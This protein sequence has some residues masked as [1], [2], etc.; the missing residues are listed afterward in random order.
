SLFRDM[1]GRPEVEVEVERGSFE[2]ILGELSKIEGI[3][4]VL[5]ALGDSFVVLDGSGER[6]EKGGVARSNVV[7]LMPLPSGGGLRVVSGVVREGEEV[8]LNAV[9]EELSKLGVGAIAV[10][11][12]VVKPENEGE[13]VEELVYEYSQ[14]L[15]EKSLEKIAR[16]VGE[17]W[18]LRGVAILHY[19]GR[20]KP[21]EK[22]IVI[23]TA[24]L[25]RKN[26]IPALAEA[27][28][29]VKFEAP[30]FKTE[31]RESGRVYIV[32]EKTV[33]PPS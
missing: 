10:F 1:A 25:S 33:K 13:R 22:T 2:E 21:G 12:G 19:V 16:E 27:L 28:E 18:G 11:V 26:A 20:R 3:A 24:G 29:R 31:V 30:V 4:R 8:D 6:L 5:E 23:A 7:H 15:L 9:V 32:G 14:E 17:K